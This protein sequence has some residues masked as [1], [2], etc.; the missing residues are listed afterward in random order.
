M[1]LICVLALASAISAQAAEAADS[2]KVYFRQGYRYFDP[3]LGTNREAM[4]GFIDH[5]RRASQSGEIERVVVSGFASPDGFNAANERLA[6]NRCEEVINYIVAKAGIDAS[7]IASEAG[8]VAWNELRRLVAA[9]PDV[10][11]RDKVLEII[12]NTPVWVYNAQG[13]I[14]DGRKKQLMDLA[15]GR[16]YNWLLANVFPQLRNALALSLYLK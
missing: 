10:P 8:G 13:R 14:V 1:W 12:D 7:L 16:P 15:G 2:A 4:N 11:Q 5:V 9:N 6:A 3:S